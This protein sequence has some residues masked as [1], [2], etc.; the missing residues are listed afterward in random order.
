MVKY[1]GKDHYLNPETGVLKN[2][3][4]ISDEHSRGE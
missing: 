4:D 2:I 1:E 3:L